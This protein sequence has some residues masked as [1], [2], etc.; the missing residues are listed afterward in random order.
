M[1][2]SDRTVKTVLLTGATGFLGSHLLEALLG[3]RYSVVALK[4]SCSDTWRINHLL[5]EVAVYDTDLDPLSRPFEENR[6]DCVIH[7]AT[8]YKKNH[9]FSEVGQMLDSNI[10]LGVKLLELAAKK[11][12][13]AFLNASTF[14]VYA[15]SNTFL[16]EDSPKEPFNLYAASK[17]AFE[18]FLDHYGK[19][20]G[21]NCITH[22]IFSP[23]GPMDQKN[24]LIPTIIRGALTNSPISLSEGSQKLDFI[25]SGDICDSFLAAIRYSET[26]ATAHHV[27][28][29][30]TGNAFSIREIVSIVEEICETKIA[31]SWGEEKEVVRPLIIADI[32]RAK[33]ELLWTPGHTLHSGLT[34]T[35]DYYRRQA[36]I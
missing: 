30:G 16:T 24:K 5:P 27:F 32:T 23:F 13:K 1:N 8:H 33:K 34:K 19:Q 4:R 10:T 7:L 18:S 35:V 20:R 29:I 31:V 14:F 25:F 26:T 12:V 3:Q 6:I 9:I 2:S 22:R 17:L 15:P 28:N 11:Q 36:K 21:M